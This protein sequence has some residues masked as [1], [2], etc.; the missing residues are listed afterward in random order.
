MAYANIEKKREKARAAARA[1]YAANPV[2]Y[3]KYR[4]ASWRRYLTI[5]TTPSL[6]RTA[7]RGAWLDE[8]AERLEADPVCCESGTVL[9]RGEARL[10]HS[11]SPRGP[12]I[13]RIDPRKGYT[14]DNCRV[15][16]S[17]VNTSKNNLLL[18]DYRRWVL[19]T[20][21]H[22]RANGLDPDAPKTVH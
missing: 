19:T 9:V 13:D 4:S 6:G 14:P 3:K 18:R 21:D 20:A 16:A 17:W 11:V 7:L 12:S 1:H 8:W 5:M 2:Q 10:R 22:I 15:V